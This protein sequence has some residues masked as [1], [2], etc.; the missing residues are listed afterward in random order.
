MPGV[1]TDVQHNVCRDAHLSTSFVNLPWRRRE[2]LHCDS[3]LGIHFMQHQQPSPALPVLLLC[4]EQVHQRGRT[5]QKEI[6][7][8]ER[9][10]TSQAISP[11]WA[12]YIC[13][14]LSCFYPAVKAGYTHTRHSHCFAQC[15]K[16]FPQQLICM[17]CGLDRHLQKDFF[18]FLI[19]RNKLQF[20][21]KCFFVLA[22]WLI[23][24]E[25]WI[26]LYHLP[27]K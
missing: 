12:Q 20:V 4:W 2:V 17:S 23:S 13:A 15:Y 14:F 27:T 18:F 11:C 25:F 8:I 10:K 22:S 26:T 7:K 6:F 9:K 1:L 3:N 19:N 16:Q 24:H 5:V 21:L